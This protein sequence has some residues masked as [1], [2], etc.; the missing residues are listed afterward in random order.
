LNT[1]GVVL[2][3][4]RV[5]YRAAIIAS[6]ADALDEEDPMFRLNMDMYLL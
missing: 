3:C 6:L 4:E 1:D 2:S 5:R